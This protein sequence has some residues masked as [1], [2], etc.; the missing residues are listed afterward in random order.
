MTNE[1]LRRA[2]ISTLRNGIIRKN[3]RGE[4]REHLLAKLDRNRPGNT[5]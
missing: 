1:Q 3:P 4:R 2:A 5:R